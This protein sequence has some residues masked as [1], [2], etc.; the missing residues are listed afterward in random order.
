MRVI[1]AGVG[2]PDLC[3]YSIGIDVIEALAE[4]AAPPDVVVEDLSYNPISVVQRFGD[5][6]PGS[7]FRRAVFVSSV[8]RGT[9]PSGT[10]ACYRWD[11]ILP[12]DS[13]IHQAITEAVTGIIALENTLVIAQHFK[14]LP[15]EVV[16]IEVEPEMHE[17]GNTRTP[18]VEEAFGRACELAREFATSD[19]A[20]ARLPLE[21]LEFASPPGMRIQ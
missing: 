8:K 4:W 13:E 10:V 15:A 2:Y 11:G 7:G 16:V 9:R 17:F 18:A 1:V 12:E 20:V 21:S 5:D 3:D 6:L 19:E 14:A